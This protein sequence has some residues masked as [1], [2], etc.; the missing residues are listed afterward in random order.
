MQYT[1]ARNKKT[2]LV[3]KALSKAHR[4][5]VQQVIEDSP[6]GI[7]RLTKWARNRSGAY[8]KGLTPSFKVENPRRPGGLVETV[9]PDGLFPATA[10]S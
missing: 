1:E 5:R 9:L 7:W 8:E 10:G 3:K 6:Q 2:G 4:R